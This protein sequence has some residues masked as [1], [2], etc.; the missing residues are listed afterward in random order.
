MTRDR[1][2]FWALPVAALVAWLAVVF[3]VGHR[4]GV[5]E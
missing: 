1:L 3:V 4:L 5:F 2:L